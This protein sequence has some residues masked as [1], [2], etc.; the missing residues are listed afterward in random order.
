VKEVPLPKLVP[1]L[2]TEYQFSVPALAVACKVTVPAPQVEP[3]VVEVTDGI[4]LTVK[5]PLTL[6]VPFQVPP[7]VALYPP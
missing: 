7:P 4:E 5:T 6:V 1:P 2:K 3:G